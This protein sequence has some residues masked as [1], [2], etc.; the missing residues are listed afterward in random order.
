MGVA[1]AYGPPQRQPRVAEA[2]LKE[3]DLSRGHRFRRPLAQDV[4]RQGQVEDGNA[5]LGQSCLDVRLARAAV[6]DIDIQRADEAVYQDVRENHFSNLRRFSGYLKRLGRRAAV[7]VTIPAAEKNFGEVA[8]VAFSQP[9]PMKG[10][11][12]SG[13][14]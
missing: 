14:R 4:S 1:L 6:R 8:E 7:S 10:A 12:I 2:A 11:P 3:Q 13:M 5:H 9:I